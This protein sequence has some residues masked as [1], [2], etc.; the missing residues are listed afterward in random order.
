MNDEAVDIHKSKPF[1]IS[2]RLVTKLQLRLMEQSF[3]A[4]DHAK[5]NVFLVDQNNFFCSDSDEYL[6]HCFRAACLRSMSMTEGV[7]RKT[8]SLK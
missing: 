2:A 1:F 7:H 3:L 5:Y 8:C 4:S 6:Y